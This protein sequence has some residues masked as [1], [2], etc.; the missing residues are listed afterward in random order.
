LPKQEK[1][2]RDSCPIPYELY[3]D[4][5]LNA[6]KK[7]FEITFEARNEIFG[8]M[9]AGAP[10][11]VYAPGKYRNE[12][13]KS[14]AFAVVP[15]D[16]LKESWSLSDFENNQYHLRV[17][18]PNG[19]F[20]EFTGNENDAALG[21]IVS[22]EQERLNKRPTGN[23]MVQISNRDKQPHL[24]LI[25]DNAYKTGPIEKTIGA[26]G[27]KNATIN[28]V[29]NQGK[30]FGWYDFTVKIKG[31]ALFQKRYAGRVE[32]G[33]ESKTDPYMGRII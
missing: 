6:D 27:S 31:N 22:Y 15:G 8:A 5:K 33:K 11:I 2:I 30:S 19:F 24:I 4:G 10:F 25:T 7:K 9:S 18:G 16:E 28:I 12:E 21:I 14:W 3:V 26:G 20:R 23:V 32:T 1:G 29:L 17:Y 13:V